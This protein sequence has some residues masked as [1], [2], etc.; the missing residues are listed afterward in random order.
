MSFRATLDNTFG[1]PDSG[2]STN[3]SS[4]LLRFIHLVTQDFARCNLFVI[5]VCE[6]PTFANTIA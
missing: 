4:T 5:T 3:K 1:R 6:Y 2:L